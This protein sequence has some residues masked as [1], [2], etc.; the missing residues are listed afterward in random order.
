MTPFWPPNNGHETQ[1]D[2]SG[3]IAERNQPS[4]LAGEN[5][6]SLR[7]RLAHNVARHC[8]ELFL[9]LFNSRDLDLFSRATTLSETSHSA[10]HLK[11][12]RCQV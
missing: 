4:L 11:V 2:L 3:L 6:D 9:L 5:M 10:A 1:A 8:G 12:S 7:E